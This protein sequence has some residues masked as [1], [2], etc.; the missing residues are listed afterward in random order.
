M[1]EQDAF[2]AV[3]KAEGLS[4]DMHPLHYLFLDRQTALA[5]R[6][7]KAALA[8]RDAGPNLMLVQAP[9]TGERL[10]APA[11]TLTA[12]VF[13]LEYHGP[14]TFGNIERCPICDGPKHPSGM[15]CPRL[16]PTST[17]GSTIEPAKEPAS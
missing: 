6:I 3:A 4:M 14:L 7:W 11:K 5:R 8:Y 15:A 16:S 1:D 2:E 10:F 9:T 12:P 17:A 13:T